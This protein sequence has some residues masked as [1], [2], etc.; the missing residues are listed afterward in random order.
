MNNY[1][2]DND[3][4]YRADRLQKVLK[5]DETPE[6]VVEPVKEVVEKVPLNEE[7]KKAQARRRIKRAFDARYDRY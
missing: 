2:L 6:E 3:Q 1:T 4:S 7:E 5:V